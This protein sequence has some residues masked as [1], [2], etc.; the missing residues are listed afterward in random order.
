MVLSRIYLRNEDLK[1]MAGKDSVQNTLGY[2]H[3]I[4]TQIMT[5]DTVATRIGT[6]N[7]FDGLPDKETTQKVYDNLDFMRGVETFLNFV[8]AASIEGMRRGMVEAGATKSNQV[9]LMERLMDSSPLFLTGNT[10]TVCASGILD[11]ET[12]GPTVVE[13]PPGGGPGTVNDAFFRFVVDMGA[14]GPDRGKGGKYLI[15][16]P[17]YKGDVP[18]GY[19]VAQSPS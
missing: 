9:V 1:F 2:N 16:P 7:F 3:K 17:G 13:I 6:L 8:P 14:P 4:P 18:E 12:D 15:L 10:D 11:L 5:P 19:F